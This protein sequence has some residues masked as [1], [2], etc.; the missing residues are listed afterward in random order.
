MTNAINNLGNSTSFDMGNMAAPT[1][2]DMHSRTDMSSVRIFSTEHSNDA[3][4]RRRP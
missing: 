4:I 1:Q 2:N 3:A